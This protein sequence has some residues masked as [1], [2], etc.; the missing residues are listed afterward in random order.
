MRG[1]HGDSGV[2]APLPVGKVFKP[3][4]GTAVTL[5]LHVLGNLTESRACQ[6]LLCREFCQFL[7]LVK[8]TSVHILLP[9]LEEFVQKLGKAQN[10]YTS[11]CT[12]S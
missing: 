9:K 5:L 3:D 1:I 12:Q 4:Q 2:A 6:L 7:F 8:I 11:T 10:K